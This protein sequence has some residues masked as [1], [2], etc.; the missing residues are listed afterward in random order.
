MQLGNSLFTREDGF[1]TATFSVRNNCNKGQWALTQADLIGEELDM[2]VLGYTTGLGWLTPI[3]SFDQLK[4][5]VAQRE[6]KKPEMVQLPGT[7]EEMI[8]MIMSFSLDM[9]VLWFIPVIVPGSKM[10]RLV[11]E[12]K[13][14]TNCIWS[15]IIKSR[16][17]DGE[18]TTGWWKYL[19]NLVAHGKNLTEVITTPRFEA[20]HR[21]AASG[22]DCL[23]LVWNHR[24]AS[25]PEDQERL[26]K[27]Q[28]FLNRLVET[29]RT[30]VFKLP[31]ILEQFVAIDNDGVRGLAPAFRRQLLLDTLESSFKQEELRAL[32]AGDFQSQNVLTAGVDPITGEVL[33]VTSVT[34]ESAPVIPVDAP[35]AAGGRKR[36]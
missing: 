8:E 9:G 20:T 22:T 32:P 21:S 13:L 19:N 17:L 5:Q 23:G 7:K 36:I 34:V 18:K 24:E 1:S 15:T 4:T 10:E 35:V 3:R 25:S 16:S 11:K 27:A 14:P 29:N 33:D 12:G 6:Q 26:A 28:E 31:G 2:I 30:H